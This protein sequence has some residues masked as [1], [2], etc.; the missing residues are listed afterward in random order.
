MLDGLFV[1]GTD[2]EVGKTV[3]ACALAR[4][5]AR[6]GRNVAVMKPIA[7]GCRVAGA[8]RLVSADAELLLEAAGCDEPL[9]RVNPIALRAP[10]APTVA[11]R[12]DSRAV[13]LARAAKSF[14]ALAR[15]YDYMVVEGIGGLAVPLTRRRTVADF[16][17]TLGL[18]LLVVARAGL[19]TLNHTTLTVEYA[20]SRG[21]AVRAVVLNGTTGRDRSEK[22]NAGEI[23]RLTRVPVAGIVPHVKRARGL[24]PILDAFEKSVDM[25]GLWKT[26]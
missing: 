16:A 8:G 11:A 13:D 2:T 17:G 7:S 22:T 24:C 20:R 18:D 6:R 12:L 15:R 14:R 3:A 25:A 9:D 23:R 5:L 26:Q 1:T 4:W 19:G 10:L 21:L